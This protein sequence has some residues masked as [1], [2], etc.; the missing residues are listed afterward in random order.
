[1]DIEIL[2]VGIYEVNCYLL[3]CPQSKEAIVIDPG[4][5]VDSIY[6]K[7]NR[8]KLRLNNIILTHAHPDHSGGADGLQKFTDSEVILHKNDEELL[9]NLKATCI[10]LGL[11]PYNPPQNIKFVEEGEVIEFGNYKLK[12]IHTPGHSKGSIC[13]LG[14][15]ELFTGDTIFRGSVGRTDLPGGSY[16]DLMYSLKNKI[17]TLDN[18]LI[19]YPGHGPKTS[20]R[21]EKMFNPFLF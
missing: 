6:Q 21:Q 14:N 8:N 9:K 12:I 10:S 19:I 4:D 5:D 1:M 20:I 18:D 7:I 17:L 11:P 15:R 16:E 2:V 3:S 13:L